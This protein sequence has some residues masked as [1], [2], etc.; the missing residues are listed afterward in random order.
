MKY[1]ARW[2]L[3]RWQEGQ[4][5]AAEFG[6]RDRWKKIFRSVRCRTRCTRRLSGATTILLALRRL[7]FLRWRFFFLDVNFH[8]PHVSTAC[9]RISDVWF[10]P[11]F[12][13]DVGFTLPQK[14]MQLLTIHCFKSPVRIVHDVNRVVFTMPARCSKGRPDPRCLNWG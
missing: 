6:V 7:F 12:Y 9:K 13:F 5:N 14:F 3:V 1:S 11:I 8:L 2:L 10:I 4:P